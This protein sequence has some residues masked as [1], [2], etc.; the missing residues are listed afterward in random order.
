MLEIK[1]DNKNPRITRWQ[2]NK[3]TT[4]DDF[5][6]SIDKLIMQAESANESFSIIATTTG[7][8]PRG[9]ALTYLRHLINVVGDYDNIERFI[10]VNHKHNPIGKAFVGMALRLFANHKKLQIVTS[11]EEAIALI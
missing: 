7:Q 11:E 8:M 10:I 4:W 9:N 1:T 3:T 2:L 6:Q 5:N